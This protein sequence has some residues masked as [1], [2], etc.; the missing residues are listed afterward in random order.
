MKYSHDAFVQH[1]FCLSTACFF[2]TADAD[3]ITVAAAA[4]VALAAGRG[5]FPW[6]VPRAASLGLGLGLA[7]PRPWLLARRVAAWRFTLWIGLPE[8][9]LDPGQAGV[10]AQHVLQLGG[11]KGEHVAAALDPG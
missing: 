6:R 3:R 2:V 7:R 10:V 1:P 9:A 8:A 5:G 4:V 11:G